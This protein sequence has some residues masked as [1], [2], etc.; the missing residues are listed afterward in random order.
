[1]KGFYNGL[2]SDPGQVRHES[3]GFFA[4]T[5]T[6]RGTFSGSVQLAGRRYPL[7]GQLDAQGHVRKGIRRAQTNELTL[8]LALDLT[9]GTD[10]I[11]GT[12][13][14]GSWNASLLANRAVFQTAS[15]PCPFAGKYTMSIVGDPTATLSPAGDGFSTF[16]VD[17]MGRVRLAGELA[18]GT[19]V[20]QSATLSRNG[21]WPLYLS[22]YGGKGSV[23]SWI[24]L[25]DGLA[26]N[27]QGLVSWTK[28]PMPLARLYPAGFTNASF[29]FGSR[30]LPRITPPS[31]LT[32]TNGV[33][34]LGGGDFGHEM[35]NAV[36][37]RHNGQIINTS[38]NRLNATFAL[39]TGRLTGQVLSPVTGKPVTFRGVLLQGQDRGVGFALGTNQTG[40][41]RLEGVP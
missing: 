11:T 31:V 3:S 34:V 35:T 37:V 33:L 30:Y 14:D 9:S 7:S 40:F 29:A 39:T 4:L 2:F 6:T 12:I 41:L 5:V 27:L 19:K 13:G 8:D 18:D 36:M 10:Q 17:S 25:R 20:T 23:L 15:Q 38:G 28:P 1:V 26:D 21:D 16:T 24:T 22:L 32:W